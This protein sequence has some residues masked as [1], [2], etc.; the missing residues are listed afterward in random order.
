MRKNQGKPKLHKAM[1]MPEALKAMVDV[2]EF[3]EEK[4]GPARERGWLG[5]S[6]EDTMD[7]LLR[8]VT[9]MINGESHDRN[10]D[11][12]MQHTPNLMR[13]CWWSFSAGPIPLLKILPLAHYSQIFR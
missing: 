2:I 3:G 4:Y 9:A 8:H 13:V 11:F 10:L 6:V 1:M 12:T 7:S 5:Y